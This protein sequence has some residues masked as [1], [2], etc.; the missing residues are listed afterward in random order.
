MSDMELYS[1][2]FPVG[3][4]VGVGIPLP[5]A[6]VFKDWAIIH[7]IDEDLVSLQLSRDV[8][9]SGV[10]LGYGQILELR[11][12]SE[13]NGYCCRAIVVSEGEKSEL[14]LRLIGEIVSD[15]LREFYRI[16]AFLPIKFFVSHEQNIDRLHKQWEERRTHR[17]QLELEKKDQ[18][19]KSIAFPAGSEP[20][21]DSLHSSV[22][23]AIDEMAP[24]K[25]TATESVNDE[26]DA[27]IPLAANI[28]GGGLRIITP[29]EFD[30]GEYLLLEIFVPLP[31]RVIDVIGRVVFANRNYAA[32][33]DLSY[34]NTGVQFVYLD[35]RD[36]DAVVT[37]ISKIQLKRIRQLRERYLY[38]ETLENDENFNI[39]RRF[40]LNN[41]VTV[42]I[43]ALLFVV[44]VALLINFFWYYVQVHPKGEIQQKFEEGVKKYR[45]RQIPN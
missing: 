41:S 4:K 24:D 27:I 35:E 1:R 38:R 29:Q 16:D 8:L 5:N 44:L 30:E 32:G 9:P 23:I 42:T 33:G 34:F 40:G 36:R 26:W 6:E 31:E 37:Y 7:N 22:N 25:I 10:S 20:Q 11:G 12:G 28:S 39:S 14:L 13:G 17:Q 45:E 19:W 3:K 21:K 2:Y 15:E 18:R 43:S